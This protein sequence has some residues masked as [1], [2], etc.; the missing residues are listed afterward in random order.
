MARE[1]G[2]IFIGGKETGSTLS[3]P[4]CGGHF[5]SKPGSGT[6]RS[7]CMKCA[8]VTCG[9]RECVTSCAPWERQMEALERNAS[10]DYRLKLA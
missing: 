2:L 5:E 1:H 9:S 4:H 7:F 10:R 3:C 6:E 8:A